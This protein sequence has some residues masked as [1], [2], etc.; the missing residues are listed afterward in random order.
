MLS[1]QPI[2]YWTASTAALG[3]LRLAV[4]TTG[5]CK[6]A[7]GRECDANSSLTGAHSAP[8]STCR[9]S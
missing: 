5:L 1:N 7:L 9:L 3:R 2:S 4:T 8:L 6:L